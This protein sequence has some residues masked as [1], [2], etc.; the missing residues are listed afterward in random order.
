MK[1]WSGVVTSLHVCPGHRRPMRPVD[2]AVLVDD[3]GLDGDRHAKPKSR[4]QV[5]LIEAE[6][7]DTLDLEPGQV[8]ENITTRGIALG[9]L[10]V[11]TRLLVG[12]SAELWITGPCAPCRRM[13]E[14]REG[15]QAYLK[16]RGISTGLHYPITLP[17]LKA[18]A[19][20]NHKEGDFPEATRTAEEILSLPMFA[21]LE[22]SE[23]RYVVDSL[24][25]FRG[26]ERSR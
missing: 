11:N 12:D 9:S 20:L 1:G 8:K 2:P 21:E 7:L 25:E 22:E 5:L 17:N 15:L 24:R 19:H 4:R 6:I 18:Y 23:I 3:C 26:G 10:S 13:D 14:I 16:S